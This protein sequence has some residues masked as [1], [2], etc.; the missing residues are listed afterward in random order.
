MFRLNP[1]H[2]ETRVLHLAR[3]LPELLPAC[4]DSIQFHCDN[5][6]V[7]DEDTCIL[8]QDPDFLSLLRWKVLNLSRLPENAVS[9]DLVM[10]LLQ[11]FESQGSALH[12]DKILGLLQRQNPDLKIISAQVRS[13]LKDNPEFFEEIDANVFVLNSDVGEPQETQLSE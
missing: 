6:S 1:K 11:V 5:C 7:G 10:L 8:V 3:Y 2:I 13:V 9:E 4:I 12:V